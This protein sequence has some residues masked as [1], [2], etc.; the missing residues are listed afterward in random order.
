[1][2]KTNAKA[3]A[4][5]APPVP[6]KDTED[7]FWGDM[8]GGF[9]GVGRLSAPPSD[10]AAEDDKPAPKKLARKRPKAG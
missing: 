3:A 9:F 2:G 7:P 10:P 6:T 8:L 5:A 1:M 4:K